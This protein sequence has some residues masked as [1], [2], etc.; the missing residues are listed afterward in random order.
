MKFFSE[1]NLSSFSVAEKNSFF[2]N[3][4]SSEENFR[5]F[6]FS[7]TK[8]AK[9]KVQLV[10]KFNFLVEVKNEFEMTGNT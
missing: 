2:E 3:V 6:Q 4:C 7:L 8:R 5:L 9:K 10:V 1:Q